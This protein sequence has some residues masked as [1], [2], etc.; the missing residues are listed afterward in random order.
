[1][2]GEEE[3]KVDEEGE[4]EVKIESAQFL[5]GPFNDLLLHRTLRAEAVHMHHLGGKW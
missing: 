5:H 4:G 3:R 1:M 2:K